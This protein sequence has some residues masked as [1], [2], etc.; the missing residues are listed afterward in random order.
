M[1]RAKVKK[2]PDSP[3]KTWWTNF[4]PTKTVTAH[5]LNYAK[6][7]TKDPKEVADTKEE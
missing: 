7:Q 5:Y 3:C 6:F 2:K 4:N 1:K